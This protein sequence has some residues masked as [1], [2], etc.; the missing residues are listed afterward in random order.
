MRFAKAV[1]D[2][3]TVLIALQWA[4]LVASAGYAKWGFWGG[5]LGLISSPA[6]LPLSPFTAWLHHAASAVLTF[7]VLLAIWLLSIIAVRLVTPTVHDEA[8]RRIL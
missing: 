3:S 4:Y 8:G 2:Y 6:L 1:E 5:A 7:Y